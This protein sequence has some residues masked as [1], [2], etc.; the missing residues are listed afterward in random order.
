MKKKD[1]LIISLAKVQHLENNFE[2]YW[3]VL[4]YI[5]KKPFFIVYAKKFRYH[6][7]C[8]DKRKKICLYLTLV[9][10]NYLSLPIFRLCCTRE[11]PDIKL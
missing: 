4:F 1:R 10:K 9:S 7:N 5:L 8:Y 3:Q 6:Y 11:H 2:L